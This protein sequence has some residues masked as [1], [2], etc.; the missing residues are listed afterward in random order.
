MKRLLITLM[1]VAAGLCLVPGIHAASAGMPSLPFGKVT[2]PIRVPIA[3]DARIDRYI[4]IEAWYYKRQDLRTTSGNCYVYW[5]ELKLIPQVDVSIL[6]DVFMEHFYDISYTNESGHALTPPRRPNAF[7]DGDYCTFFDTW[8]KKFNYTQNHDASAFYDIHPKEA[9]ALRITL[10][11][12]VHDDVELIWYDARGNYTRATGPAPQ[13]DEEDGSDVSDNETDSGSGYYVVGNRQHPTVALPLEADT[14]AVSAV[15]NNSD[16][17]A[18]TVNH[19]ALR[20]K[21]DADAAAV[22]LDRCQLVVNMSLT[23]EFPS[24]MHTCDTG[25]PL[26]ALYIGAASDNGLSFIKQYKITEEMVAAMKRQARDN[27]D[28]TVEIVIDAPFTDADEIT[29]LKGVTISAEAWILMH[30]V[31]LYNED[32]LDFNPSITQ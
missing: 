1:V 7:V 5:Y 11:G 10:D 30:F 31:Q 23:P 14:V 32:M 8:T 4:K 24:L 28:G 22:P 13:P 27:A 21:A 20:R 6:R 18:F 29:R 2:K 3:V 12:N 16:R 25:Q 17:F 26:R 9:V 15:A 19:V